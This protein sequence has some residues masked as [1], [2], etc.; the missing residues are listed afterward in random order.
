MRLAI[1]HHPDGATL[2]SF[3]AATLAEPL[4]A[5]VACH[6]HMCPRCRA[7]VA[8]LE[9]LGAAVMMTSAAASDIGHARQVAWPRRDDGRQTQLSRP[10]QAVPADESLPAPL[11]FVYG[12]SLERVSWK[13]LGPGI[14]QHRLELRQPDAGDLR[15]LRIAAGKKMPDHGHRGGELTFVIE[16]SYSDSTGTYRRGDV[17]DVDEEIEHQPLV[18]E[19]QDCICLIAS[20]HQARFKSILGRL[21]QPWTGM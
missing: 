20:E 2:M 17:Q 6:L 18:D 13:R 5:V 8:D 7:E 9:E 12:L 10:S 3:A 14:W 1:T 11:A 16:G 19:G 15:L 21:I 4:A